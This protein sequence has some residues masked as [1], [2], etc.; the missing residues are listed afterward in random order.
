MPA[1]DLLADLREIVGDTHVVTDPEAAQPYAQDWTRRWH[2]KPLAVVRPATVAQV[3]AVLRA[4]AAAGVSLVPQGGN[5]GLVGGGV[6]HDGE[7]V[8]SLARLDSVGPLDPL[9]RTLMAGAGVTLAQLQR[10]ARSAGLDVGL[11]FSARDTATVG[12][13]AATNAGGE[14]VMRHGAAR[15]RIRGLEVVLADGS[16]VR[17]MSGVAKD[18]T[19]Y[20]LV[21]LM[22]GS[23]GTLGV[24]TAV[25]VDLIRPHKIVGTALVAVST[26]DDALTVLRAVQRDFTGLEAAEFF[27]HDGLQLVLK[28]ERLAQPFERPHPL[29]LLFDLADDD[30]RPD[31]FDEL[32]ALL[33]DLDCVRDVV[34]VATAAERR[35]LWELRELQT[36]AVSAEGVPVKLDVALPLNQLSNF[37]RQLAEVV[38]PVARHAVSIIFGH[39]AEGNVHVNLLNALDEDAD[40]AVTEAVLD[41]VAALGGSISAEHGIGQ[42]NRR[43][44]PLTRG[45]ADLAAMRAIKQA[46]D[47]QGT[48]SPGRMLPDPVVATPEPRSKVPVRKTGR[49][50]AKTPR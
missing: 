50:K 46:L 7:V 8:L 37:E 18:N 40:G 23:E 31:S 6:P 16:V 17:R 38:R 47:P 2:G 4:C 10:A 19:G 29:Y 44:L 45:S 30:N 15:F 20:D 27:H 26:V 42:A 1:V 11:D 32:T 3:S 35:R 43:W 33:T 14:R 36:E 13:I 28:H 9:G 25:Q 48:L 5:T 34:L 22:I 41:L 24:I 39:I 21:Q 12:G 49:A